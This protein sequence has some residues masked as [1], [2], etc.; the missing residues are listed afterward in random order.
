VRR[1]MAGVARVLP[2]GE[3]R[4][5]RYRARRVLG[6]LGDT[7]RQRYAGFMTVIDEATKARLCTPGFLGVLAG[8]SSRSLLEDAFD[9]SDAP[10][11]IEAAAHTDLQMYL[12]GALMTKVDIGSMAQSL[13]VRAQLL[14]HSLVE[15]M[16]SIP[17]ALKLDGLRTKALL[18]DAVAPWLP[19]GVLD[20]PKSGFNVPLDTWLRGPLQAG[21]RET[22]LDARATSRGYFHRAEVE[23][24]IDE[25]L[26][27]RGHWHHQLW[28]LLVLEWWHRTW[29]DAAPV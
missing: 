19:P 11:F 21:L 23:R 17:I 16:A 13:E 15:L 7:P 29:I 4:T 8:G 28:T 12:P 10:S 27:G 2:A 9:R 1:G 25:H 18:K 26:T 3:P 20:R 22:L 6:A 14:D 24:L 5:T